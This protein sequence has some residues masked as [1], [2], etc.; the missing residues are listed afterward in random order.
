M[1]P[2][3]WREVSHSNLFTILVPRLP[4][5]TTPSCVPVHITLSRRRLLPLPHPLSLPSPPYFLFPLLLPLPVL[6]VCALCTLKPSLCHW[7]TFPASNY[8]PKCLP[9]SGQW[10]NRHCNE[11]CLLVTTYCSNAE[12]KKTGQALWNWRQVVIFHCEK[13]QPPVFSVKILRT[14]FIWFRLLFQTIL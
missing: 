4:S 9:C 6:P 5:C 10:Q 12:F 7:T 8:S 13:C 14:V 11:M 1:A 3:I 2:Y